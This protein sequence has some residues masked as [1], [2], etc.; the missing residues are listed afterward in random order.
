MT[1]T[2]F[3]AKVKGKPIRRRTASWENYSFI[4]DC[5]EINCYRPTY[6][7]FT[8]RGTLVDADGIIFLN[9]TYDIHRLFADWI[10]V[11]DDELN[12]LDRRIQLALASQ[13]GVDLAL[14]K[15]VQS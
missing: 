8:M 9:R 6:L 11:K 10:F 14:Q 3:F 5:L 15:L 2:E 12:S 4:P 7:Y 1:G 13:P